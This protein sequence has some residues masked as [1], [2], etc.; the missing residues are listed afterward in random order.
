MELTRQ[1]PWVIFQLDHFDES[2]ASF[3]SLW[4]LK[5]E[6]LLD[7]FTSS[8]RLIVGLL[9]SFCVVLKGLLLLSEDGEELSDT[10]VLV[11]AGLNQHGLKIGVDLPKLS[12]ILTTL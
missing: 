3:S 12:G 9:P 7:S 6:S 5:V 10:L 2:G 8:E 1:E 11:V 4:Q